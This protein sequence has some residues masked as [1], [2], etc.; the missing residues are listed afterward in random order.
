VTTIAAPTISTYVKGTNLTVQELTDSQTQ[1]TIN[2]GQSYT[3]AVNDIDE[4]Q[5]AGDF[6]AAG[7]Y[8]AGLGL[9][10]AFDKYIA[11]LPYGGALAGNKLGRVNVV[12]GGTNLAA[13]TQVL[14]YNLLVS[15]R[16]KLDENSV[17]QEG[18]YVIVP[19]KF[20]SGLLLD[21]RFIRVNEAGTAEGLRN[22][23]VG[24]V[25]GL[26]VL[27][28]NNVRTVNQSDASTGA[29]QNDFVIV[30]GVPDAISVAQQLVETEAVRD[31]FQF[32]DIVRGVN[33]YGAKVFR[34]EGLAHAT[35]TFQPG[36]G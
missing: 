34:P 13:S 26:D 12:N 20:I 6:E 2:Q 4:I 29:N 21:N 27:V 16:E 22:G 35:V 24:R 33:I 14:A 23:I 9:R 10:D 7:L 18:R 17:P 1:L 32:R 36:T 3:F 19:P 15:L 8:M 30:A 25:S 28:S 31:P 5:A 11:T